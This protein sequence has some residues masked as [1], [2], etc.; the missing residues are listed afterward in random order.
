M[1]IIVAHG[2]DESIDGPKGRRKTDVQQVADVLLKA[3][4][5]VSGLAVDGTPEC[6]RTLAQAQADLVFNLVESFGDDETKE[7]PVAAYYDLLGLRY[8]GSGARG[9]TLAMDK[10]LAKKVFSFHGLATPRWAVVWRGRL[11]SAHD[12]D[13]PV[14]VQP[15]REEGAIGIGL[16]PHAGRINDRLASTH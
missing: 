14:I 6:L 10:A 16:D 4:H 3:G 8:T 11:D 9:L 12:I 5:E 13:F 2:A 1:R 7:P 15:A